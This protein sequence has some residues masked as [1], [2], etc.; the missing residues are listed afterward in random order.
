MQM[1]SKFPN[2]SGAASLD[3]ATVSGSIYVFVDPESDVQKVQFYIDGV[4]RQT[5]RR[6]PYDLAG[7]DSDGTAFPFNTNELDDGQYTFKATVTRSSSPI[8]TTEAIVEV[9]N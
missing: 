7:T 1:Y 2:R 3:G 5:E 6:A 9:A 8:E 4:L